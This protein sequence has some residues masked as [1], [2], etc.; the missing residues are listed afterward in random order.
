MKMYAKEFFLVFFVTKEKIF[1]LLEVAIKFIW[2]TFS[3][4]N[5]EKKIN[6]NFSLIWEWKR[7]QERVSWMSLN[8]TFSFKKHKMHRNARFFTNQKKKKHI[9]CSWIERTW[10][11]N[12]KFNRN[13]SGFKLKIHAL[14]FFSNKYYI[15]KTVDW[16][17]NIWWWDHDHFQYYIMINIFF[18]EQT[19]KRNPQSLKDFPFYRKYIGKENIF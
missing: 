18:C 19:N 10:D 1:F 7:G 4:K 12:C 17:C 5:E 11:I 9:C 2:F 15:L 8:V 13:E 6:M 14:L 3:H 16:I